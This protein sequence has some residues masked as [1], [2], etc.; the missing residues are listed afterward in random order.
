MIRDVYRSFSVYPPISVCSE[1]TDGYDDVLVLASLVCGY[2][3]KWCN[4]FSWT[5]ASNFKVSVLICL[6]MSDSQI[7]Q[8]RAVIF[9]YQE[10][11][12]MNVLINSSTGRDAHM[13]SFYITL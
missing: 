2:L 10:N 4:V 7:E 5:I 13:H 6:R 11:F 9:I 12:C 1:I 8:R 3:C